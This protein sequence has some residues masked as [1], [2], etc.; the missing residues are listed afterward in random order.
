MDKPLDMPLRTESLTG[1][2]CMKSSLRFEMQLV[3][4][5][6]RQMGRPPG[7]KFIRQMGVS[8]S[9]DCQADK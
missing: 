5:V 7:V 4:P 3:A 9:A 1:V 8:L 6:S 2:N